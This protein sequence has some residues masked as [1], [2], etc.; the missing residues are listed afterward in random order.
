M[1]DEEATS[2]GS[3]GLFIDLVKNRRNDKGLNIYFG[4]FDRREEFAK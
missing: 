3:Q 2:R 1:E 4:G